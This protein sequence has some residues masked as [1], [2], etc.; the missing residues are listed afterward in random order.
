MQATSSDAQVT[1]SGQAIEI[2]NITCSQLTDLFAPML[3]PSG[4]I[5]ALVSGGQQLNLTKDGNSLCRDVQF[6]H[7]T[8]ILITR[9]ASSLYNSI[10]D[11]TISFVLLCC[12]CF[13]E[14]YKLICDGT[15]IPQVV[16]SLQLALKDT[17]EFVRANAIPLD[18]KALRALV[19]TSLNTKIRNPEFLVDIVIKAIISLSTTKSFDTNMIEV[20]KMEEG[21]IRDSEFIEGLVLDHGARHHA[22]PTQLDNVCVLIMNMS[23]EFE[24]PEINA[25]FFYNSAEQ[26]DMLCKAEREFILKKAQEIADF[27]LELQ[28]DG[29]SL[30]VVSEKGID[31]FSLEVLSKANVL[32]LRRAKRRNLER[33]VNMCGG[34]IVT[35]VSQITRENLGFC[36]SVRSKSINENSYTILEGTPLKGSCTILLRGDVDYE[37]LNR[38][39]RGTINSIAIAL[40]IKCCI[41]GGIPMY[42]NFITMLNEKINSLHECDVS[43]YKVLS[44]AFENLLKILIKNENKNIHETLVKIFREEDVQKHVVENIKVVSTSI[45][46]AV[47]TAINLLMCD[48]IIL[49]GK[50]IKQDKPGEE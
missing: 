39:I 1:Q 34:K 46:N 6:T 38:S 36:R 24:K 31:Q 14:A 12:E 20:I 43:G 35:Q 42:R 10:G 45:S 8:S 47:I 5:K 44:K 48:E 40:Q 16:N 29:K 13:R 7:P 2:N 30:L 23:L 22:M 33:L 32:A 28:K 3:G 41:Y 4:S 11:G 19:H 49:A 9:A 50:P 37:R 18:D 27:A 21:D 17:N 15:P 25:E 26:R